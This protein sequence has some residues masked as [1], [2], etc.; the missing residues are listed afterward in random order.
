VL[1]LPTVWIGID[2]IAFSAEPFKLVPVTSVAISFANGQR[3]IGSIKEAL[4][5]Q[6]YSPPSDAS[7]QKVTWAV[8]DTTIGHDKF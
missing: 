2:D 7:N 5:A 3:L 6:L 4:H 1:F 8:S